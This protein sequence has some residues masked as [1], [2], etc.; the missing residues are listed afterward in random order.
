MLPKGD[1]HLTIWP[2]P[3]VSTLYC[4]E[5]V[6]FLLFMRSQVDCEVDSGERI[7]AKFAIGL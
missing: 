1:R 2:I 6:P 5:P 3:Q 4:P 7:L